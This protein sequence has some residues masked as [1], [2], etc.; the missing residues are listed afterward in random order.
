MRSTNGVKGVRLLVGG[1]LGATWAASALAQSV[2]PAQGLLTDTFNLSLGGFVVGTD[3]KASLN[4]SSTTNPDVDF[5]DSLGTGSNATRVRLDGLWRINPHH[6][7]RFLYFDNRNSASK[8]IDRDIQWGDYTFLANGQV[9]TVFKL[10]TYELAYEYAFWREPNYEISG[11]IGLHYSDISLALS[12]QGTLTGGSGGETVAGNVTKS[13]SLAAPLP[14]IGLRAGWAVA[15]QWVI[16]AQVQFF[17]VN[18]DGYDGNWSDVR[19]GATWMFH[20]NW[21]LGLGYD[22]W[23]TRVDVNKDN[24]SGSLNTHYS[25]L[26]AFVTGSF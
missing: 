21:G 20:R 11:T 7:L 1:V 24:F 2:T 12:G 25:G 4:G 5:N 14:V 9:D 17:K 6:H 3:L 13:S 8:V 26:Q 19:V 22:R 23:S 10:R 16:D 18:I 15:P